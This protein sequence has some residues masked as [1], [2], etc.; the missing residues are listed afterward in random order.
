MSLDDGHQH[1]AHSC[2][3]SHVDQVVFSPARQD[4]VTVLPR[5]TDPALV[6]I[7][8]P[9]SAGNVHPPDGVRDRSCRDEAARRVGEDATLLGS[10][11]ATVSAVENV[12]RAGVSGG[13]AR[14][15]NHPM[16]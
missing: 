9:V 14:F 13:V 1:N 2:I 15:S 6:S 3:I 16:E 7:V 11:I 4:S 10:S 8:P 12:S 5:M